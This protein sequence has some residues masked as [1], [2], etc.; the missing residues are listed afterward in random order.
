MARRRAPDPP[1]LRP[2]EMIAARAFRVVV[3][4]R[5]EG[6]T[7]AAAADGLAQS[8][9]NARARTD[10]LDDVL[11]RIMATLR[12]ATVTSADEEILIREIERAGLEV[13]ARSLDAFRRQAKAL[14]GIDVIGSSPREA[15]ILRDYVESNVSLIKTVPRRHFDR[16]ETIV[17]DGW[18]IG[19]RWESIAAE[20][21]TAYGVAESDAIRIAIDQVGKVNA[22][23]ARD[24]QEAAGVDRFVWRTSKDGRVRAKHRQLEGREFSWDEG[25][26][27]ER[28][29][30]WPIRCRCHAEPVFE[31]EPAEV[32]ERGGFPKHIGFARTSGGPV[33][34]P[35]RGPA[36]PRRR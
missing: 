24:R 10:G 35:H 33:P 36:P 23:F 25:H 21:I 32:R 12:V 4:E 17:R 3:L 15:T 2:A 16:V 20:M 29:P 14:I 30:G 9:V 22:E 1:S 11:E 7:R 28:I 31:E 6:A 26:P 34:R 5:L 27:T 8:E 18:R 13:N 19:R